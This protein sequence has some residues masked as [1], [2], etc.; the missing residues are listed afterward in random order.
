MTLPWGRGLLALLETCQSRRW[1]KWLIT[2]KDCLIGD[3]RAS[4]VVGS[5][6]G[7]PACRAAY[8]RPSFP[9]VMD[10]SSVSHAAGDCPVAD[11]GVSGAGE[12]ERRGS[13]WLPGWYHLLIAS[14]MGRSCSWKETNPKWIENRCK[15]AANARAF[16]RARKKAT[17]VCP[18]EISILA[19][20]ISASN[21]QPIPCR[22]KTLDFSICREHIASLG[23]PLNIRREGYWKLRILNFPSIV[24]VPWGTNWGGREQ[25]RQI[26]NDLYKKKYGLWRITS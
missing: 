13:H 14:W 23:V 8:W 17:S 9:P 16:W 26:K 15:R 6:T 20:V 24:W 1:W 12:R 2:A 3:G 10:F 18:E 7:R 21:C 4:S 5:P 11:T 25:R 19:I 22:K